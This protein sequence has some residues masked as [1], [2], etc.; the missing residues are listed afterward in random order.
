MRLRLPSPEEQFPRGSPASPE[1]LHNLEGN[2]LFLRI[3]S[4]QLRKL[5]EMERRASYSET[6]DEILRHAHKASGARE[7]LRII[8]AE[9][10]DV[11]KG[12][13]YAET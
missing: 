3:L 12:A 13:Q 11:R 6:H 5:A 1:D 4:G 9:I 8:E 2:H 7:M 10:E